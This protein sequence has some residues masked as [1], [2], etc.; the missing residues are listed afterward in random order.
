MCQEIFRVI[1][2]MDQEDV[3]FQLALQCAPV[4]TGIKISNLL[5]IAGGK[6][7]TV[8]ELLKNSEISWFCLRLDEKKTAFLLYRKDA[9][10][11]YLSR[12]QVQQLLV[13]LGYEDFSLKGVLRQFRKHYVAHMNEG[14]Q[15]PHE[16]GLLLGY[17][18]ED[19]V[20]FMNHSG[21]NYLY[22]GYWKVYA[23]VSEKKRIFAQYDDAR[24]T[25]VR[26]LA[27][28]IGIR[29]ILE[30]YRKESRTEIAV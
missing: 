26:L 4:I 1:Q 8:T 20:G 19:V 11:R 7:G 3:E 12:P 2:T 22:S 21:K 15:F 16:M 9:L 6:A 10:I 27:N 18:V 17:P 28:D 23:N 30:I 5:M 29:L 14:A 24:E 13:C 25:L